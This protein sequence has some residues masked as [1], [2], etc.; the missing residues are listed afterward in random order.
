MSDSVKIG[1]LWINRNRDSSR[2]GKIVVVEEIIQHDAEPDYGRIIFNYL[3]DDS[4][5][6]KMFVK[7]FLQEFRL[8]S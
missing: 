2:W 1:E 3:H 6:R 4:P 8:Y 5:S 7:Y